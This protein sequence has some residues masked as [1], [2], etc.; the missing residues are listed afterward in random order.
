MTGAG[1]GGGTITGPGRSGEAGV[2]HAA[3]A[4][5]PIR[6]R[7]LGKTEKPRKDIDRN[8]SEPPET[9]PV[10]K[11]EKATRP[12]PGSQPVEAGLHL[13]ATPIGNLR[14]ITL[15]AL[16]V[17]HAADRIYAEDTRIARKLLDAYGVSTRAKAC[18]DHNEDRMRGAILSGLEA[19]ECIALISDAGTPLISDPGYKIARDAIADGYRVH[20]LPG[21][22]APIAALTVSGLPSDTFLF[23]GFPPSKSGARQR[24]FKKLAN[25]PGTLIF[26]ESAQR[27]A[28]SLA[29]MTAQFGPRPAAVARELTKKF[30]EV[31]RGDLESLARHYEEA[32][33]PRGEIVVLVGPPEAGSQDWSDEEVDAALRDALETLKVKEAAASVAELSGWSKRDLYARALLLKEG[34]A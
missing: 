3:T 6:S 27:L 5:T 26:F 14:D 19:G 32:G 25:V 29:D 22:S 4:R 34:G 9:M 17:L 18:H 23:D 13:V 15:R 30:E 31:R 21:A 12:M 2:E 8:M 1:D 11:D 10:T 7:D 20:A 28:A 33:P 16:D 24:R